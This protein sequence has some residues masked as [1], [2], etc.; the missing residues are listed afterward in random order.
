MKRFRNVSIYYR[1]SDGIMKK[2]PNVKLF[3][4]TGFGGRFKGEK[5]VKV[6]TLPPGKVPQEI[7]LED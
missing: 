1:D 6:Y 3:Y 4:D 7:I 2:I 5:L